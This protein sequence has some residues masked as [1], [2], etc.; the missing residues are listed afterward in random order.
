MG[1]VRRGLSKRKKRQGVWT[2]PHMELEEAW[3]Y[4]LSDGAGPIQ[5][6]CERK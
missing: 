5:E 3:G 6:G 2:W 1:E 4:H